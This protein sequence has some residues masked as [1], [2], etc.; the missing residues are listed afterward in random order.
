MSNLSSKG[1]CKNM[2]AGRSSKVLTRSNIGPSLSCPEMSYHTRVAICILFP[3]TRRDQMSNKDLGYPRV[4]FG[5]SRGSYESMRGCTDKEEQRHCAAIRMSSRKQG[6]RSHLSTCP[7]R[8]HDRPESPSFQG[9][10][11]GNLGN[12]TSLAGGVWPSRSYMLYMIAQSTG[13]SMV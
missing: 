9:G 4:V 2:D 10:Q 1:S 11:R 8:L 3:L 6:N 5:R 13:T 7:T 12:V